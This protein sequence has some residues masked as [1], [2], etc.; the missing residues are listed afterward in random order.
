MAGQRFAVDRMLGRLARW[1]RILGHDVAYGPHLGG[2]GLL[3]C[4]R[5]EGR[6]VL[7][8]DTR[9]EF[10]ERIRHV[11]IRSDRFRDQL[12]EVAA[13][14]P[15]DAS[16]FLGRCLECNRPLEEVPRERAA[17]RVP[18]YVW[19]TNERFLRCGRCERFYW[20]ATHRA[21]MLRE[22]AALGLGAEGPEAPA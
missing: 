18:P 11:F 14:V 1:L 7:T 20:P 2:K 12:R 17:G 13:A 4:A 9:L 22:L 19:A 3:A 8:R 16:G 5:R 10:D 6:I 21:H 15:L